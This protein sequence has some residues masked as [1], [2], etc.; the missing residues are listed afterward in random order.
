MLVTM[1][2]TLQ[3]SSHFNHRITLTGRSYYK[4]Y[5]HLLVMI[6]D[7]CIAAR[8]Y[9][10]LITCLRSHGQQVTAKMSAWAEPAL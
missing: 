2:N 4:L 8:M 7:P 3:A 1:L 9:G 5:I 10:S 6:L